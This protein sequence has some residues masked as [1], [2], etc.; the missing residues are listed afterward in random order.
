MNSGTQ[1]VEGAPK[2][3]S[4]ATLWILLAVCVSPFLASFLLYTYAPP[5]SRV[6]YGELVEPVPLVSFEATLTDG[7]P[8]GL[9]ELKGKWTFVQVDGPDC[10]PTCVEKLYSMRQVRIAQGKNMDRVQRLWLLDG[11]GPI[12]SDLL[13]AYEG[14]LIAHEGKRRLAV[15]LPVA[16]AVRDHIW[17]IDPLGNVMMRY[18]AHADPSGIKKD[19]ERLLKVSQ[20]D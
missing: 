14:T 8:L 1:P 11:D 15:Q 19:M 9:G 10:S 13:K 16:T 12:N 3:K 20:I 4:L 7:R 18:P 6:N 5:K 2:G 17:I